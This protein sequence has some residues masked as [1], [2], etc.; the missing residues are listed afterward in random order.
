MD[1][2]KKVSSTVLGHRQFDAHDP[3]AILRTAATTR[4]FFAS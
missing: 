3:A 1:H 4:V 2:M